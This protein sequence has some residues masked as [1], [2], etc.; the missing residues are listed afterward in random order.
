M[1][2]DARKLDY[3]IYDTST[4]VIHSM[5]ATIA[6]ALDANGN[7]GFGN[8]IKAAWLRNQHHC[9][10][11][12]HSHRNRGA[13]DCNN[14]SDQSKKQ[15]RYR[16]GFSTDGFRF[17]RFSNQAQMLEVKTQ[18]EPVMGRVLIR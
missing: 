3:T 18:A 17:I 12:L 10:S 13:F 1:Y 15:Y 9:R 6:H 14:T 16:I 7:T 4:V 8:F 11:N 5:D 2:L